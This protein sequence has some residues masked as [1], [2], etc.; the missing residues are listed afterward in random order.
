MFLINIYWSVISKMREIITFSIHIMLFVFNLRY[1][2]I[3]LYSIDLQIFFLKV[4][5][6]T[7]MTHLSICLYYF[8][9]LC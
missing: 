8:M 5:N 4:L 7:N 1:M 6:L 2:G 3:I 9:V